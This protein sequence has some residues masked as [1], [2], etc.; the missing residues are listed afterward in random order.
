M[1][2]QTMA[3]GRDAASPVDAASPD[4]A[5][6]VATLRLCVFAALQYFFPLLPG[7]DLSSLDES[8]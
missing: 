5:A 6:M 8:A 2:T 3:T 4:A 1:P 7:I